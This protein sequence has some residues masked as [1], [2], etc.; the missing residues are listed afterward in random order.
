MLCL[1]AAALIEAR[2]RPSNKAPRLCLLGS[3]VL[4][5]IVD[6]VESATCDELQAVLLA[7]RAGSPVAAAALRLT[8]LL[9]RLEDI[10]Y[11]TSECILMV[12]LYCSCY[13]RSAV[14]PL[15]ALATLALSTVAA[16][17]NANLLA[18]LAAFG[19]F[20]CDAFACSFSPRCSNTWTKHMTLLQVAWYGRWLHMCTDTSKPS[21]HILTDVAI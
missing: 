18:K 10:R 5:L 21:A 20:E 6:V 11:G 17:D 2:L 1:F 9:R 19:R 12:C 8:P 16:I 3:Q 4:R 15:R 13:S 7:E 14:E